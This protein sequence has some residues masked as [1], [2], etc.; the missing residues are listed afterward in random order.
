MRSSYKSGTIPAVSLGSASWDTT[1]DSEGHKASSHLSA[2]EMSSI[3]EQVKREIAAAG[4]SKWQRPMS[5][6][7]Y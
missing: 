7:K 6:R 2:E 1:S 4:K 5:Q 3:R